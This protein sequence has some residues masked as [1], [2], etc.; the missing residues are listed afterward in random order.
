VT[1]TVSVTNNDTAECSAATFALQATAPEGWQK[2][3]GAT[4][5]TPNPGTTVSTTLRI[6]SAAVPSGSYTIVGAAI[7]TA[8]SGL[9]GSTPMVYNVTA[10]DP[11]VPP[12]P[13]FNDT[14]DRP[15][16]PVLG[17]GWSVGTGG[18]MIETGEA[19]NQPGT[20]GLVVQPGLAGP[21]QMVAASFAS[22]NNNSAP[23][24]GVVVRYQSP[25]NYYICYRQV[26]GS[27]AL[28][29]AKV[30]NGVETVLKSAGVANPTL[31]AW[32]RLSCEAS[33]S[34]LTLKLDGVAKVTT[35]DPTFSTGNAGFSISSKAGA[36]RA[37]NFSAIVQ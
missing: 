22:T 3:F 23:R 24:F 8:T 1:Y 33:G 19:R 17:N 12:G 29:V 5:V 7:S 14:F 26:G 35:T 13:T 25:Q 18:M 6:T 28:R 20:S 10:N 37:D 34:T 16:A 32:S 11:P 36:H 31:N 9:S 30:Q 4:S 21:T 2:I 27:S 15:N